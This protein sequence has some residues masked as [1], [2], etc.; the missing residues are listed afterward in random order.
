LINPNGA[1]EFKTIQNAELTAD[2]FIELPVIAISNAVVFPSLVAPITTNHAVVSQALKFVYENEITAIVATLRDAGQEITPDNINLIATEA[3]IER[4]I[5]LP[6]GAYT[7]LAQ[8]RRRVEIESFTQTEPFLMARARICEEKVLS[9]DKVIALEDTIIHML[10][11]AIEINDTLPED[12]V[13]YVLAHSDSGWMADFIVTTLGSPIELRQ[14]ILETLIVDDRLQL[15]ADVFG[16]ELQRMELNA[17][18][19]GRTHTEM[20]RTQREIFLREQ[21]RVIQSELGDDDVYLQEIEELREQI[22][23]A[24]MPPETHAKALKE[25]LRLQQTPPIA[26]EVGV[27]RSYLDW[28]VA[29]PWQKRSDDNLDMT[30]ASQVLEEEHHGLPK[31]KERILEHIAVRKL[32]Q[33][34]MKTPILCFVGPP[35]VGKTSMGKS[36]A[37]ALGREFVRVSLGGVRDD[38]EIRGHRRTY[39]GA[40]PGRIIQTMRNAGT[41]N[42]VFMLDE[43]D[44][45]GNDYRGDPSAALLEAL[46]PEQN[47]EYSDH[48]LD[49]PYDLSQVLFVTTANDLYPIEP[50]LLDRMEVIEFP[51]YTE[52]D[53]LAIA[54]QYLIPQQL[55]AHGLNEYGIKF[56]NS[57]LITLI[58]DYTYEAGVRNLN[59]ELASVLRKIARR[60]AEKKPYPKRIRSNIVSQYLGA[61]DHLE[62]RANDQDSVGLATGLA[63]TPNGGDVLTI[64]VS[65]L[66]GKGTLML[67]GQLGD[68][69][70]ESAQTALSYTRSRAKDLDIPNDDFENYDVH[71][72]LPEGAIPKD[73]PSA[74]I[75]LALA[76]I[77]AFTEA[78][79]RADWTMTGEITL[80]G[81]VLPVGGIKEKLIAA[82]RNRIYNVILPQL[83][84]KDL[85][86]TP[87]SVL[88]D[89]NIVFVDNMQT[90]M[91]TVLL[92]PPPEGRQRDHDRDQEEEEQAEQQTESDEV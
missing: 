64:E 29:L 73:G 45:L 58:R 12:M 42:P 70:Q 48:Y 71:I 18:I 43:I 91:D 69:M 57:A 83:N 13:D 60:V 88:K 84:E 90:I 81:R 79:I 59:R 4:L 2:G 56:D 66:P 51:S 1:D 16:E 89:M 11:E 82:H 76:I 46:D 28:L 7:A 14:R 63:W 27:I 44:K 22:E 15:A 87:K 80:R 38:A 86:D 33:D 72:H 62:I 77:S 31:V 20:L 30:Y 53:K 36:I 10:D 47:T 92:P 8:G 78:P 41:V 39:I 55:E 40:L 32:A 3:E 24:Q 23:A 50:A 54:Q 61:P 19:T 21:M 49:V 67:T 85:E 74:G 68:V 34:K 75:T 37:K 65:V 5:Q 25:L 6:Y 26:P 35:G 52:Y 9:P 17:E